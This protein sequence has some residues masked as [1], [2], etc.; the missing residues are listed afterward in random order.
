MATPVLINMHPG[1]LG[2]AY[3]FSPGRQL[4]LRGIRTTTVPR[5]PM[6]PYIAMPQLPGYVHKN[7]AVTAAG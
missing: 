7:L 2:P 6:I 4:Y 1:V 3:H 5:N